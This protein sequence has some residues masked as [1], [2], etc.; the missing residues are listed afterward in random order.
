MEQAIEEHFYN[1]GKTPT[2]GC[3]WCQIR[4]FGLTVVN[5]VDRA[6]LPKN[7]EFI[8][9]M[10][11]GKGVEPA[12]DS[13]RSGCSC[14]DDGD[15]QYTGCLC[16]A[17][18]GDDDDMDMN[19]GVRKAYA[20]HT[21]G[22]KAGLLRSRLQKSTMPLYECHKGCACSSECPNRVV[23][24]GRT[25]PLQIFRTQNRGWG[26]RSQAP[27]KQGQFVDR[28]L[29][30]IITA[31]EAD[32]RRANSAVSQQKDVY[33]FALDKFTDKDS[34]DPR[35]NGPPL[36]VDGEFMSGPTRFINHSCDPNLRIFARVGDH[37]DKHIHDL[38]LFAIKDIS[39]GEEL[40]FDYVDGVVEEQDELDGNV[41][42]YEFTRDLE[43]VSDVYKQYVAA[44]VDS[45]L[46]CFAAPAAEIYRAVQSFF[47]SPVVRA[48]FGDFKAQCEIPEGN[49]FLES[50][51]I[52]A[53]ESLAQ[54]Y[55]RKHLECTTPRV[56]WHEAKGAVGDDK[57]RELPLE[58]LVRIEVWRL[59]GLANGRPWTFGTCR[60]RYQFLASTLVQLRYMKKAAFTSVRAPTVVGLA[61]VGYGAKVYI[62]RIRGK[63][64]RMLE[65]RYQEDRERQQRNDML[66]DVYGDRESLEG[67]EKA[68]QF[69]ENG[70]K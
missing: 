35:L 69:Y 59:E 41:E 56:S 48:A 31:E 40:T 30:E 22:A 55:Y 47:S 14:T 64:E 19:N 66:L 18:L 52:H 24:R 53:L 51:V 44:S 50:E 39:R 33:L 10:V 9:N 26:V 32:R 58:Y 61:I 45:I 67:L 57:L 62:D 20:Y 11:L 12:E 27:I 7:F 25:V 21:H 16:L 68:I 28:Y 34:L 15:C 38:A 29:G 5:K 13:F 2:P 4:A 3:H 37:A 43:F 46:S 42:D 49:G 36:E 1:H 17:D 63:R 65:A 6:F 23:E 70:K 54:S 8:N 60:S